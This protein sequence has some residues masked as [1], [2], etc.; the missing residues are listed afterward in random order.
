MSNLKINKKLLFALPFTFFVFLYAYPS[1]N[2]GPVS[3]DDYQYW[4]LATNL[5]KT[6]NYGIID[7]SQNILNDF[8][9]PLN[10]AGI[11][12]GEVLYTSAIASIIY[13]TTSYQELS[14]INSDCIYQINQGGCA[15]LGGS[16][17]LFNLIFLIL[18]MS[19]VY[20]VIFSFYN[21]LNLVQKILLSNFIFIS[22]PYTNKDFL[23]YIFLLV[24]FLSYN[25][26]LMP[27]KSKFLRF[28]SLAFIPLTNPI[29]YYFLIVF[30]FIGTF[31]SYIRKEKF[32]TTF[33]L[34]LISLIPSF[35][36][37]YR[38]YVH[39]D[40]FQI[41]VRGS[42]TIG[43]RAEFL[44][45]DDRDIYAGFV[46]YTPGSFVTNK[47]TGYF[48][49][50]VGSSNDWEMYFD[51]N[52]PESK[53]R[54]GHSKNGFVFQNMLDLQN[55]NEN[56]SFSEFVNEYGYENA[57]MSYRN[58]AFDLISKNKIKYLKTTF[59]FSYRGLFPEFFQFN[60]GF[61]DN[62]VGSFINEIFLHLRLLPII[63]CFYYLFRNFKY[64]L[65]HETTYLFL[66][67]FS[68]YALFT[69]FIPRYSTLLIPYT[70]YLYLQ[71]VELKKI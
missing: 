32:L 40:N 7:F 33:L 11:R 15:V 55:K 63:Y 2:A 65:K 18:R 13:L 47:F 43:I 24:F 37:S 60:Q 50:K 62:L 29:F 58:S 8:A 35:A 69:H 9:N 48:W 6:G 56:I 45:M 42:E 51:R 31:L 10:N 49:A 68:S 59:L 34:I 17:V 57:V 41:T 64:A 44:N 25:K 53:Y 16:T 4:Y 70:I 61:K 36:W 39:T 27:K 30:V 23:T 52:N 28:F 26:N 71:N 20:F 19:V 3:S 46:Y 1:I 38:N 22:F 67:I 66:Y 5:V 21:K 54:K 12:R 14:S